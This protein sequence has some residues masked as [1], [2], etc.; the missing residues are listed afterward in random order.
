M[1]PQIL[2]TWAC[3]ETRIGYKSLQPVSEWWEKK[4]VFTKLVR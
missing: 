3:G 1:H 2:Q 4:F